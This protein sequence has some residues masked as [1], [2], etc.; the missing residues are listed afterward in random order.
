MMVASEYL[1]D[2]RIVLKRAATNRCTVN[3]A[4]L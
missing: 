1:D 3:I 4:F 2:G